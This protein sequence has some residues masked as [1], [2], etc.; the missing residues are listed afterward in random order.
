MFLAISW[1]YYITFYIFHTLSIIKL[2]SYFVTI[3]QKKI[4]SF[5]LINKNFR[6]S[7]RDR[8][9][10]ETV[11]PYIPKTLN[12]RWQRFS[13][14]QLKLTRGPCVNNSG[15][16]LPTQFNLSWTLFLATHTNIFTTDFSNLCH[17][18]SSLIYRTFCYHFVKNLQNL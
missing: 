8:F 13:E 18:K 17:H 14:K 7:L 11:N 2:Y 6:F 3:K 1:K 5:F 9:T 16:R 12:L 15:V 4:F 10:I